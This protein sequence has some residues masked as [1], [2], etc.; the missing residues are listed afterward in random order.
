M[1]RSLR[2]Q[3]MPVIEEEGTDY[4]HSTGEKNTLLFP[5]SQQQY[6]KDSASSTSLRPYLVWVCHV[7]LLL[8]SL[9]CLSV[10]LLIHTKH[11][12]GLSAPYMPYCKSQ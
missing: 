5:F 4:Y 12:N 6:P 1:K 8:F 3:Y 10:S 11:A 2:N 7:A 9:S